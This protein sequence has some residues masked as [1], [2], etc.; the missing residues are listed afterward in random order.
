MSDDTMD[1]DSKDIFNVQS[2]V[3]PVPGQVTDSSH[4]TS[5]RATGDGTTHKMKRMPV[6]RTTPRWGAMVD[7]KPCYLR[8]TVNGYDTQ[9][10]VEFSGELVMGRGDKG[11]RPD[12]D[13]QAYN[14]YR[15]G[16]SRQH[17]KIWYSEGML[18]IMDLGST[19][20]SFLNGAR[21][22]PHQARILRD[23][24]EVALSKLVMRVT[25]P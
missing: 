25:F 21:L 16:V 14:A 15:N 23:G 17:A 10:E 22:P 24:D 7:D 20:G 18:K 5:E 1:K 2:D 6:L 19:N 8:L 12:L 13:L 4:N 3:T 11:L 9:I